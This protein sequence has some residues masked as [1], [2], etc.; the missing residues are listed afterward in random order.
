MTSEEQFRCGF[1]AILGEPNVG[2]STFLNAVLGT[3]LSIVTPKPQTTRRRILGISTGE[4]YQMLFFDTPGLIEPRYLLQ[5]AMV[6]SARSALREAD[7]L[8]LLFDVS[9]LLRG[10][11]RQAAPVMEFLASVSRPAL[12]ILNKI[13]LLE[14]AEDVHPMLAELSSLHPFESVLPISAL[15]GTGTNGIVRELLRFLPEHPALYPPDTLSDLPD[16]FF[17]SEIVRE[18]I[19]EQFREEVPYSTE[20]YIT[21]YREQDNLDYIAAEIVVER[22]SQRRI[23]IGAGG[24]AVKQL[25]SHARADIEKYLGKKV[26]L[27]LHVKIRE[28]WRDDGDWIRRFGYTQ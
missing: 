2:K 18:K 23:I 13:D 7:V 11:I 1:V 22:E 10:G 20:V 4:G 21:Q 28:G 26:Y 5:S 16:R 9:K 19:F 17:V 6:E 3:K 12:A 25:G 15:H 27:D 8:L 24:A 14:R